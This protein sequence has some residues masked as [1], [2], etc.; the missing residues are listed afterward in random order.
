MITL[1]EQLMTQQQRTASSTVLLESQMENISMKQK[2]ISRKIVFH[3]FLFCIC[4]SHIVYE[5][6][7]FF[8]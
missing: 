4:I 2:E 6:E 8:F 5:G 7:L 1:T 3:L